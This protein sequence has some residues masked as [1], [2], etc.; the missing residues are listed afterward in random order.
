MIVL[1]NSTTAMTER[2]SGHNSHAVTEHQTVFYGS[3][4]KTEI[5]FCGS[6]GEVSQSFTQFITLLFSTSFYKSTVTRN[7]PP[8]TVRIS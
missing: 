3:V 6:I 1:S 8:K 5:N 4:R 7:N 2:F